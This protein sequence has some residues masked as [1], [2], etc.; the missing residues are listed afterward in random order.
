K[1]F[2]TTPAT[3]Y[4]TLDYA[5]NDGCKSIW[6]SGKN[7]RANL[8]LS[9]NSIRFRDI[10]V[11]DET[12]EEYHYSEPETDKDTFYFSYPVIDG[13]VWGNGSGIFFD[14]KGEIIATSDLNGALKVDIQFMDKRTATLIM[15]ED[16]IEITSDSDFAL[17]YVYN[18]AKQLQE[19]GGDTVKYLQD[20]NL[21][22]L[23]VAEGDLITKLDKPMINSVNGK[24]TLKFKVV[25]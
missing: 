1:Q 19:F 23:N 3:V 4:S 6:Y 24:I 11:F 9:N 18:E 14:K 12:Y 22:E 17:A 10:N 20:G 13:R 2:A 7:Y 16:G 21:Y 5:G 15:S 8:F 25:K